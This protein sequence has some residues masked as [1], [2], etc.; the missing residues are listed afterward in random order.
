MK[1]IY[2]F[3]VLTA[4]LAFTACSIEKRHYMKGYHVT[5]NHNTHN[6]QSVNEPAAAVVTTTTPVTNETVT[7]A[8][9]ENP[10][11]EPV[12]APAV[13]EQS[14]TTQVNAPVNNPVVVAPAIT[15]E[16][17]VEQAK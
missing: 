6:D 4:A 16:K 17:V 2:L 7:P 13:N 10:Q 5:W 15:E 11:Q 14:K 9:T 8:P 1:K 12:V 3:A